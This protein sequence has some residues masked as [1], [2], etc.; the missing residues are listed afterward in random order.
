MVFPAGANQEVLNLLRQGNNLDVTVNGQTYSF[1]LV[2]SSASLAALGDCV[3][4]AV[5]LTA[6][7][8]QQD[9]GMT[10]AAMAGLLE[11]AGFEDIAFA[12]QENLPPG[13]VQ[14]WQVN[15]VLGGLVQQ[16][17]E[18]NELLIDEF[19]EEFVRAVGEGC[20]DPLER[21]DQSTEIIDDRYDRKSTIITSQLPVDKWHAY[22]DEPTLADAILD[23][24][25]H[26]SYRLNLKGG[27][28]RKHKA[29]KNETAARE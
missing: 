4:T 19:A 27:S 16:P 11:Q 17:R 13:V 3:D 2:G 10:R 23:R 29:I 24:L 6:A 26:N 25:I 8:P 7:S 20:P 22:L 15:E 1:G 28:M 12:R 5:E 21:Q 18:T 14:G 9:D